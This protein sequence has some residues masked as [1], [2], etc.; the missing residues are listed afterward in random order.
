MI[1][2]GQTKNIGAFVLQVDL[3]TG[4]HVYQ[5]T[6]KK[7]AKYF[8]NVPGVTNLVEQDGLIL[9]DSF[10]DELSIDFSKDPPELVNRVEDKFTWVPYQAIKDPSVKFLERDLDKT[11]GVII[12]AKPN[13]CGNEAVR[14]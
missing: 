2:P 14:D 3:S 9:A 11:K 10:V 1:D 6:E 7:V 4:I 13:S 12:G 5:D 8:I